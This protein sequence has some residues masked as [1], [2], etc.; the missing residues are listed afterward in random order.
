[1]DRVSF[2]IS[3]HFP[4]RWDMSDWKVYVKKN[5]VVHTLYNW[6]MQ[7]A[8]PIRMMHALY[9]LRWYLNDWHRYSR[10]P[11]AEPVRF[12]DSMPQLHDCTSNTT[13]DVHY[14]WM[15]GWAMRRI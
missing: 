10:L 2:I 9:R 5:Q 1:M 13:I 14:Y 7:F 15:S 8:D 12:V 3:V 11:D 4:S 6:A